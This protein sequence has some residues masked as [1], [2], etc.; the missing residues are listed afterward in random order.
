MLEINIF[1]PKMKQEKLDQEK[2]LKKMSKTLKYLVLIQI[3]PNKFMVIFGIL[4]AWCYFI[5]F[6]NDYLTN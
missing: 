1:T 4:I 6:F 5:V 2:K 3:R